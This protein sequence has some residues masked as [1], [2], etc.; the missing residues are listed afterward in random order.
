[1]TRLLPS[2]YPYA[3]RLFSDEVR[4]ALRNGG[5]CIVRLGDMVQVVLE[6][7]RHFGG[8]GLVCQLDWVSDLFHGG[9]N[10]T[11][12][13]GKGETL[14]FNQADVIGLSHPRSDENVDVASI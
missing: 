12:I 5:S 13:T 10:V 4:H 6:S 14:V 7:S 8:V 9:W 11:I 2:V 3:C 1:M